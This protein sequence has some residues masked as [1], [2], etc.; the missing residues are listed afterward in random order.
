MNSWN[1]HYHSFLLVVWIELIWRG[2]FFFL[3]RRRNS[4]WPPFISWRECMARNAFSKHWWASIMCIVQVAPH[5][6]VIVMPRK[7]LEFTFTF[8][9]FWDKCVSFLD[10]SFYICKRKKTISSPSSQNDGQYQS[11]CM[12]KSHLSI[13]NTNINRVTSLC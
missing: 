13:H 12:W 3:K 1:E 4:C 10:L 11:G 7:S 9:M 6:K 8:C 2:R 5:L